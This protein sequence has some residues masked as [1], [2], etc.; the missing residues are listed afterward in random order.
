MERGV[1]ALAEWYD[2]HPYL[3]HFLTPPGLALLCFVLLSILWPLLLSGAELFGFPDLPAMT[4]D[5]LIA[6]CVFSFYASAAMQWMSLFFALESPRL[7]IFDLPLLGWAKA[8]GT[9]SALFVWTI[10]GVAVFDNM[11]AMRDALFV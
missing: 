7:S 8:A 5:L 11:R 6:A 3:G 2:R 4:L 9:L 10:V 1:A